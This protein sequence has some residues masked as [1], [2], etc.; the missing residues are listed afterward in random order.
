MTVHFI[1]SRM[2]AADFQACD[3]LLRSTARGSPFETLL[4]RKLSGV[5]PVADGDVDPLAVTINSRVEFQIDDEAPQ[6]RI[7]VRNGFRNGLVGL[8]L[9][10]TTPRGMALLGLRPGQSFEFEESGRPRVITVLRVPYQPQ[11]ARRR[12][13]PDA[14]TPHSNAEIVSLD[15]I[16]ARNSSIRDEQPSHRSRAT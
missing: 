12:R 4:R 15:R 11:A 13:R 1:G 6:M 7:L 10:I 14:A 16:R 2:A 9:P 3:A 8:T 5:S